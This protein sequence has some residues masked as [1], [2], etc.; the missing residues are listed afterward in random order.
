V[1][2]IADRDDIR[3]SAVKAV[4]AAATSLPPTG[5][6]FPEF[7]FELFQRTPP[8]G[9]V[10]VEDDEPIA[11]HPDIRGWLAVPPELD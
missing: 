2:R 3:G 5:R 9:A 11:A 8:V 1:N 10:E 6:Q 4:L 7:P